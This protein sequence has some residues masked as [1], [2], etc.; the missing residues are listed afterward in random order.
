MQPVDRQIAL[1][2]LQ[3]GAIAVVLAA[4]PYK[5]FDLDRF[6]VPKELVLSITALVVTLLCMTRV[7][8]LSLGRVDELLAL[9]LALGLVSALFAPNWW[10]AG[11]AVALSLGGAACFWCARALAR[12]GHSRALIAALALAGVVG[13][14][15]AL[16]QAYG[17]RTEFV[18]LN[19]APGG[20]FG[21]RNFMAHLCVITLPALLFAG[22]V[23]PTRAAFGRWCFGLAVVAGALILS[24]SRAAWL[25][26]LVGLVVFAVAGYIA[27]RRNDGSIQPRRLL[28]L[29]LA[30][31]LGAGAA[32]VIPNTLDWRSD[33]PYLD[34]A[35]SIVNYKGGSGRGRLVQY[36]NSLRMTLRHPLLGV[37]PGNWPVVYPKFA[38]PEDPS[39]G[40]DGMTSNPWP[41][42]DWVTFLSERGPVALVVLGLA[43][44]ALVIDALR[45]LRS[46]A[47]TDDKFS[48]AVLLATIVILVTVGTFDAVLLLPV[49]A[50]V[51]WALLG[52]LA[53]PSRERRAIELTLPRR[54]LALVLI[55]A[56]GALMVFRSGGQLMAMSLYA[57]SARTATLERASALDP[58]SYRI[59]VR[60]AQ[61]Y[62]GRGDCKRGRVHANAA[63]QLF[64]S[65]PNARRL[66]AAC[67]S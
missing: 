52:A 1:R 23:A 61:L 15:T 59:H 55:A 12:G 6:F 39:L 5:S 20:T 8:R 46:S 28:S 33:S 62:I 49:A 30:A 66:A 37:G 58:G 13:A 43:L 38:S 63:K 67:G 16:L 64:P 45:W 2:L 4:A 36:G 44:L 41:S 56:I 60:L 27:L 54:I 9:W 50:L 17:V 42:S 11:R 53:S 40:S 29:L 7:K 32:L 47:G 31:V 3:F 24:R 65:S 25:A 14:A 57:T 10:L 34:T 22:M 18:S 48:A 26:L 35:H 21:N 19:R 51:G